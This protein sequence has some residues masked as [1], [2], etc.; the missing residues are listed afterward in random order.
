MRLQTLSHGKRKAYADGLGSEGKRK[1]A[2]WTLKAADGQYY[3]IGI[4][5]LNGEIVEQLEKRW[6][7]MMQVDHWNH[8]MGRAWKR[9]QKR[10]ANPENYPFNHWRYVERFK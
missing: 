8:Y 7:P 6:R 10:L 2:G 4:V 1:M 5:T 9:K 3:Q